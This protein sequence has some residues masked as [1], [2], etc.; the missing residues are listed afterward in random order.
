MRVQSAAM[1]APGTHGLNSQGGQASDVRALH[2]HPKFHSVT[3]NGVDAARQDRID[4]RLCP[5]QSST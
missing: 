2:H 1:K 3:S 4:L 5:G